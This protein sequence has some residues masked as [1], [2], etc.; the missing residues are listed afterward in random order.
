MQFTGT[1]GY[2]SHK[3]IPCGDR[4][5][6]TDGAVYLAEHAGAYWLMDAILSYQPQCRRDPM[7][8]E[9][10]FW[11]L[12]RDDKG[13]ALLICERDAGDVAFVQEIEH[14]DFP[15]DEIKLWVER[16]SADGENEDW[17][18]MLPSER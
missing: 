18:L 15:L 2:Q 17:I 4:L 6:L 16:G 5:L 1:D 10:Q 13:G 7:L 14:T 3:I 11:T 12:K 8:A 9:M